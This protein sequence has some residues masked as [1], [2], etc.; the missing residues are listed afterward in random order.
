MEDQL[1]GETFDQRLLL[2]LRSAYLQLRQLVLAF[3]VIRLFLTAGTTI[4]MP[5]AIVVV[6]MHMES[7]EFW[8]CVY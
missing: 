6:L 2:Q 1:E 7:D 5:G 4:E 3:G 8:R